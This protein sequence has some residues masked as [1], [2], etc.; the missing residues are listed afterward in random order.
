MIEI[1]LIPRKKTSPPLQFMGVDIKELNLVHLGLV[2]ALYHFGADHLREQW[3]NEKLII[4]AQVEDIRNV[5]K[6][7]REQLKSYDGI[8]SQIEA[9]Q[10]QE[11]KLYTRL[12]TVKELIKIKKNPLSILMYISNNAPSNLWLNELSMDADVLTIKGST[13][14]YNSISQFLDKLKGSTY[15]ADSLNL[16]ST[17]T[18]EDKAS[19]G[20]VEVFEISTK[21]ARYE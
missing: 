6:K 8:K 5:E 2:V 20:R 21:V 3:K 17:A 19:G 15:F 9:F 11:Q 18:V 14:S 7:K 12:D 10:V 4:N 16:N 13:N 1:N